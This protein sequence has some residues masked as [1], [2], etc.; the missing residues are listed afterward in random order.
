MTQSNVT[1][2]Y[3]MLMC[4]SFCRKDQKEVRKLFAGATPY[5]FICDV[6]IG[7]CCVMMGDAMT[8]EAEEKKDEGGRP[9]ATTESVSG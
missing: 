8:R 6:C 1:Y 4:C 9:Q 3:P 2:I 5:V 7:L